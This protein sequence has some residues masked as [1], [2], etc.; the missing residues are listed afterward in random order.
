MTD[1]QSTN[2]VA[3]AKVRET[4]FGVTPPNPV[5]KG[6]RETSSSLAI[7]P[8]TVVSNEIRPDR[9][10]S[11]LILVGVQAGGGRRRNVVPDHG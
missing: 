11:D 4:T 1:L 10:V 7:N 9:Q 2:R 3:I 5:F 8:Q 6:I